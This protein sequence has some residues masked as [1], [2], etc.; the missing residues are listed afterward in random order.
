MS[1]YLCYSAR[2]KQASSVCIFVRANTRRD[3][4][5][6]THLFSDASL[7]RVVHVAMRC[8]VPTCSSFACS[9]S[10]KFRSSAARFSSNRRCSRSKIRGVSRRLRGSRR[11]DRSGDERGKLRKVH[12][13]HCG[14][15]SSY[16][17]WTRAGIVKL[18]ERPQG[19]GSDTLLSST[20]R[21]R[22]VRTDVG[23][24]TAAP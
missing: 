24:G 5:R 6:N 18:A 13:K 20:W 16:Q 2:R 7:A 4:D 1:V 23:S 10:F 17:I 19:G 22:F 21:E 15:A 9:C 14:V 3:P 12:S 11:L 8:A